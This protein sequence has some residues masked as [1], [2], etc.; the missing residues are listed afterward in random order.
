MR[1]ND[2]TNVTY[3]AFIEWPHNHEGPCYFYPVCAEEPTHLVCLD[4]GPPE[5]KL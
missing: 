5:G 4:Y 2:A 1:N 3:H